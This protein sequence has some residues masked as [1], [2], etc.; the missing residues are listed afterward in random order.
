[1]G[2]EGLVAEID[3]GE[4]PHTELVGTLTLLG[5]GPYGFCGQRVCAALLDQ[6]TVWVS[7]GGA[8]I[9]AVLRD[10][11][12]INRAAN[13]VNDVLHSNKWLAIYP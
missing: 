13:M 2:E 5:V 1:M 10:S 6:L 11:F 3:Q 4:D 7:P 8:L 9:G 12:H